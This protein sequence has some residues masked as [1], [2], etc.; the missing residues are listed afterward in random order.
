MSTRVVFYD[1]PETT[2]GER[3]GG[4]VAAAWDRGKKL[5]IHCPDQRS[6]EALDAWLWTWREDAFLPH[7]VVLAG[8]K[9]TDS[10][11]R[12]VITVGEQDPIGADLLLQDGP[13][14]LDFASGFPV[15]MDFVDHRSEEALQAS[16]TRFKAWRSRGIEPEHKSTR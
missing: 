15:V 8:A 13:T 9:P 16:R 4:L 10:D 6:A 12:I 2:R 7:E 3:I 11:A 14:S 5:L 1:D